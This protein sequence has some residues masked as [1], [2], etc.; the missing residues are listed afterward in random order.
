MTL[1]ILFTGEA[2][3]LGA[4]SAFCWWRSAT[5]RVPHAHATSDGMLRDRTVCVDGA[6]FFATAKAQSRWN[7]TAAMFA[8]MTAVCQIA[9]TLVPST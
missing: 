6:D 5:S 3:T 8:A 9:A 1:W 7:T 4:L 2:L